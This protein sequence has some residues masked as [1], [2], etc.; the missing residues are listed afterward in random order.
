M[1]ELLTAFFIKQQSFEIKTEASKYLREISIVL[2]QIPRE[3]LLLLKTN[4]LLRG[5][6]TCLATRNS[7]S[8][9]IHMIKCCVKLLNSYERE[10]IN[11]NMEIAVR[12]KNYHKILSILKF[13]I[14][15]LIKENLIMLKIFT[16]EI[17]L[18]LKFYLNFF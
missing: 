18:F 12:E 16:F 13:D 10:V 14:T 15:S 11:K 6:E 2:N 9:F 7:S 1:I 4:D 8:S 3:M 17:Y 5:I